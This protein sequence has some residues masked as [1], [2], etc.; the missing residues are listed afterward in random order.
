MLASVAA[1]GYLGLFKQKFNFDEKVK[2]F[3]TGAS[4]LQKV[5]LESS[6]LD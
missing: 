2:P 4:M 6:G 1:T 3:R 5:L